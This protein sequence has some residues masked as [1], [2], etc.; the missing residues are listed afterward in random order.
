M[1]HQSDRSHHRW[2]QSHNLPQPQ[3]KL[4]QQAQKEPMFYY[5][6]YGSCMCPVDLK[7]SLGENTHD[8]II[9]P[10]VLKGYRLGF[11]SYSPTRKC[12][13]LDVLPDDQAHVKG[14]LY[15]LPWRLSVNLDKRE[16][17]SQSLYR[18]E[19]VEIHSQ[20][21]VYKNT[22]TYIVVNKL[23]EELAPNDWYSTVVLRGAVTCGLPEEYCWSLFEHMYKLQQLSQEHLIQAAEKAL[24][25]A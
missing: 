19:T 2:V 17:V 5:F 6:A 16:G 18:R 10:A 22:R 25:P 8:Y 23:P 4:Q 1:S 24:L 21:N 13:V 14:V 15:Q 11:Y 12:G 3:L 7:R 9:G 20:N